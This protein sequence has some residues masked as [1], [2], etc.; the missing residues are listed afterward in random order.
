MKTLKRFIVEKLHIGKNI[1]VVKDVLLNVGEY[2][3]IFSFDHFYEHISI[4]SPLKFNG[5]DSNTKTLSIMNGIGSISEYENVYVNDKG[6]YVAL[7]DPKE[8]YIYKL[9]LS[10]DDSIELMENL[11]NDNMDALDD[12]LDGSFKWE[13]KI[14]TYDARISFNLLHSYKSLKK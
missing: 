8:K 7:S 9:F 12:Y 4:T 14:K 11:R 6:Y 3:G 13:Q 1:K 10:V 2:I 5:Y